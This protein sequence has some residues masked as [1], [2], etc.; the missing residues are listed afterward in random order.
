MSRSHFVHFIQPQFYGEIKL[1]A[2]PA[3]CLLGPIFAHESEIIV[4]L[5]HVVYVLRNPVPN[6]ACSDTGKGWT[7]YPGDRLRRPHLQHNLSGD[8]RK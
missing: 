4:S 6:P 2:V 8:T 7:S 5:S 1:I 3:V